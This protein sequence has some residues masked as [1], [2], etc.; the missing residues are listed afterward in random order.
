MKNLFIPVFLA[1][2]LIGAGCVS[3]FNVDNFKV[4]PASSENVTVNLP[5]TGSVVT[6]PIH[7]VGEARVFENVISWRIKDDSGKILNSGTSETAALD[8]GQFGHFDFWLTVPKVSSPNIV[9]EV[10]QASAKDG[11]DQDLVSIPLTLDRNDSTEIKLYF[12]NDIFDPEITCTKVFP[13]IRKF[14]VT[15]S[16]AR[17]AIVSLLQGPNENEQLQN[18]STVIPF[19]TELKDIS[20]SDDGLLT[21]DLKG[22][23][24]GPIGG[25]C[26][27]SAIAAEIEETMK[28]FESVKSVKVLIDG[29]ENRLEP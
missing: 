16:I 14:T 27:V 8:M 25:S 9:L 4:A 7:V 15:D 22:A 2:I 23:I 29:E 26:Y 18:Y 11:S 12:H 13:V 6:N 20:L 21:V 1:L 10:F 5:L 19:R 17:A 28:Q 3:V 24:A